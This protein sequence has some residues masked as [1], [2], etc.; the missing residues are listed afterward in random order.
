MYLGLRARH[1]AAAEGN[2]IAACQLV[3]AADKEVLIV[4]DTNYVGLV[5]MEQPRIL[6]EPDV[7]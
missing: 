2:A 6:L 7:E 3:L 1:A 5:I 4:R